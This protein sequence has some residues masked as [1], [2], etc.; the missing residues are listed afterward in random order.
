VLLLVSMPTKSRS[1]SDSAKAVDRQLKRYRSMRNFEVT[2][3]PR[4]GSRGGA[5]P[6]A[7]GPCLFV[8]QKHAATRL[9]Y[10]FRL[11]WN[12]VLKSWA[13]TKG[14]S[15]FPGDKRLAV[16]VE[17]HPMEYGGF[18]GTI[19]KGQYGGGTVMIWDHG[20]WKGLGNIE[21]DLEKGN[22]KFELNGTKLKGKWALV[23]MKKKPG[24]HSDK[25][26]WLLFKEND[27]WAQPEDAPAITDLAPNSAITQR[28][29]EQIAESKDHVWDSNQGLLKRQKNNTT[30]P[31]VE[32]RKRSDSKQKE[33]ERVLSGL[34]TEDFPG[35]IE[36]QF[37][38]QGSRA[39]TGRNWIHE[40]KLDGYRIQV[41][42]KP[43]EKGSSGDAGVRLFTRNGLDWTIRMGD[44][45]RSASALPVESC[46]LDGE[47]VALDNEG[48]SNFSDL[49]AAF[50]Q[51]R[52]SNLV[53]FAF[54][55]LHLNGRNLRNLP[56]VERKKILAMILS[57]VEANS[58]VRICEHIEGRGREVF[59]KACEL[60]AEGIVSKLASGGHWIFGQT[61]NRNPGPARN[62]G[63]ERIAIWKG[64]RR[65]A[66][67]CILG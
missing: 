8:V 23:R 59:V 17:D 10:D 19:P 67:Q 40:L 54:D 35:F 38:K 13:V 32:S 64:P 37:A 1:D 3:E 31:S 56:L 47:M 16:E 52:L 34:Q 28:T 22:L 45:A 2:S 26:N 66:A 15:Y 30:Q 55:I 39:P 29:M 50:Q 61:P 42:V 21:R 14:P 27:E 18:E 57:G 62:I 65:C 46:I 51:R 33:I 25:P 63:D 9:H 41:H 4:G 53:Y 58:N 5:R 49:Q 48:R 20:E 36:P 12:G 6:N 44:F 7:L 24:D 43:K 60:G 11:G